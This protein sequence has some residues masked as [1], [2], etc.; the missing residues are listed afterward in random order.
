MTANIIQGN[1]KPFK[2]HKKHKSK[3]WTT[4]S[5]LDSRPNCNQSH[6][7]CVRPNKF[8]PKTPNQK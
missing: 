1:K 3:R 5:S 8:A 7:M 4:K 6:D 2:K